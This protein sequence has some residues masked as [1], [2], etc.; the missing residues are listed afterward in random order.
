MVK[1]GLVKPILIGS[2]MTESLIHKAYRGSFLV[3]C[4][5]VVE[6]EGAEVKLKVFTN[7]VLL[8]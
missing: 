7:M 2:V 4:V 3:M 5:C 6:K 1:C 8:L